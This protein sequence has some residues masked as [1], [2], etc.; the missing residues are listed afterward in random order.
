MQKNIPHPVVSK[1][2]ANVVLKGS[3]DHTLPDFEV[4]PIP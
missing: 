3:I 1:T 2:A 4:S